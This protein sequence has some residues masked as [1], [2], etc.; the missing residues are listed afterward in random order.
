[1]KLCNFGQGKEGEGGQEGGLALIKRKPGDFISHSPP[2]IPDLTS[3][4]KIF[5]KKSTKL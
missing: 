4:N 3:R 2:P 5:S 1:M